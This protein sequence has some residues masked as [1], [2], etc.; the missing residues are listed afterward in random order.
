MK[1]ELIA[2][3]GMNCALCSA[4]LSFAHDMK[5]KGVRI[6]ACKGCRPRG[7]NCAFLKKKCER[8]QSG[9]VDF[10]YACPE[11]PCDRLQHLDK[12]YRTLFRMSMVENG[13]FIKEHGMADFLESQAAQ[14]RCPQCGGVI[15]CHNGICYN[16]SLEKLKQ[17]KLKYRWEE[18]SK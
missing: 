2:P 11:F 7:K 9:K 14:W 18:V 8:L 6:S 3:C 10:C 1:A 16:C 4:Y 5:S 15:C 17:K 12:R 13:R